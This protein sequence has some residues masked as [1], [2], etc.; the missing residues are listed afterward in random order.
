MTEYAQAKVWVNNLLIITDIDLTERAETMSLIDM[1]YTIQ[2]HLV[3][4]TNVRCKPSRS[5]CNSSIGFFSLIESNLGR[6]ERYGYW[7]K[8]NTDMTSLTCPGTATVGIFY[9]VLLHIN[10]C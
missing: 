4:M 1:G 5:V 10:S 8:S 2:I 9:E 7:V 6:H 3:C